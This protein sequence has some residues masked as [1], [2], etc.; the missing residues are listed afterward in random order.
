MVAYIEHHIASHLLHLFQGRLAKM[1]A[2]PNEHVESTVD[3]TS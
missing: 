1:W 3:K 2:T